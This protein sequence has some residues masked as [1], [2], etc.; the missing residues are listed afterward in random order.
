MN[1]VITFSFQYL[2]HNDETSMQE[3]ILQETVSTINFRYRDHGM[4]LNSHISG[5]K[6]LN[7]VLLLKSDIVIQTY[8]NR[9]YENWSMLWAQSTVSNCL[10]LLILYIRAYDISAM[11]DPSPLE[12]S[13]SMVPSMNSWSLKE[14]HTVLIHSSTLLHH[15]TL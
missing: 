12:T 14:D 8:P 7:N 1:G 9:S 15:R 4:N 5:A 13:L 11:D 3:R 2:S 10:V 6:E